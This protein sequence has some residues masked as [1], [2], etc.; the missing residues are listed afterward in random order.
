MTGCSG[1]RAVTVSDTL[2]T[3]TLIVLVVTIGGGLGVAVLVG[4]GGDTGP[5][6]ANFTFEHFQE[7]G[8]LLITLDRG[9]PIEAGN[10]VISNG[11]RRVTWA[12]VASMN[13]SATVTE[14]SVIQLSSRS[15][16]G[17]SVTTEDIIQIT[18]DPGGENETA[19][20]ATWPRE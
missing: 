12:T 15:A 9:D 11:E 17:A 1:D 18:Y 19:V 2:A 6:E 20:L 5:P 16:Y 4:G 13:E 3:G 10:L 14:G 7:N 8:A